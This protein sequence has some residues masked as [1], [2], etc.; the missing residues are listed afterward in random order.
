MYR[1]TKVMTE[2][3]GLQIMPSGPRAPEASSYARNPGPPWPFNSTATALW[4][5]AAPY[6]WA[7]LPA[8]FISQGSGSTRLP[9]LA[10]HAQHPKLGSAECRAKQSIL[11]SC[12]RQQP[13]LGRSTQRTVAPPTWQIKSGALG[14]QPKST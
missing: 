9:S 6:F 14:T 1:W 2:V 8:S 13:V 5:P 11:S 10:A 7:T 3:N 12:S 4:N